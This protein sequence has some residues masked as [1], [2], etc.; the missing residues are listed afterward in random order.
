MYLHMNSKKSEN[1][2]NVTNNRTNK[3]I[4]FETN[5]KKISRKYLITITYA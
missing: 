4:A 3:I 5:N 1:V 2:Q